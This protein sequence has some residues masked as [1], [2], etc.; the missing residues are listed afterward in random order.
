MDAND[1]YAL[2]NALPMM[3]D[4]SKQNYDVWIAMFFAFSRTGVT[5]DSY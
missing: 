2:L 3:S 4:G 5:F 1:V